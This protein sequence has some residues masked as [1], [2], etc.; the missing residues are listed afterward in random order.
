MLPLLVDVAVNVTNCPGQIVV[1]DAAMLT[2]GMTAAF[3]EIVISFD[4]TEEVGKQGEDWVMIT[5]TLS[6]FCN[7]A[8]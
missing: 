4:V 1:A 3:T 6:P 7:D 2:D 5:F 8:L